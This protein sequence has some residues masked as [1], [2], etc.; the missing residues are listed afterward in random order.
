MSTKYMTKAKK[1]AYVFEEAIAEF[2]AGSGMA[3]QSIADSL[4]KLLEEHDMSY[5]DT[6]NPLFV[7]VEKINRNYMMLDP[8]NV[9]TLLC[10]ILKNGWSWKEVELAFACEIIPDSYKNV[11]ND[12]L[13][14]SVRDAN[15]KLAQQSNGQLAPYEANQLRVATIINS[16]T[17]AM[18]RLINYAVGN[19]VAVD[20]ELLKDPS[21]VKLNDVVVNGYLSKQRVIEVCPSIKKPLEQGMAYTIIRWEMIA[22]M[23]RIIHLIC[24]GDNAKHDTFQ[25][26]TALQTMKNLHKMS[27]AMN[28]STDEVPMHMCQ[29]CARV[30]MYHDVNREVFMCQACA[31]ISIMLC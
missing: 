24:E 8:Q 10:S 31:C 20:P 19:Q 26:E 6:L 17:T 30:S 9:W 28:A 25:K 4:R 23:P 12:H 22:V 2:D 13:G 21:F 11:D 1:I 16:H 29:A 27:V 3:I 5:V 14:Q 15:V 18:L 7:G